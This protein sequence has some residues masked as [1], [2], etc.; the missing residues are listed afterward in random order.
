[1]VAYLSFVSLQELN[2]VLKS[3]A[4]LVSSTAKAASVENTEKDS[5]EV[6]SSLQEEK[7]GSESA[8][9]KMTSIFLMQD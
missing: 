4:T 6:E 2:S 5:S 8:P 1:M 7:S 3:Q 9:S